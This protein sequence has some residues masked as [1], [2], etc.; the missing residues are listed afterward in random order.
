MR[1]LLLKPNVKL[2]KTSQ[3]GLLFDRSNGMHMLLTG[4]ESF[5]LSMCDGSRTEEDIVIEVERNYGKDKEKCREDVNAFLTSVSNKILITLPQRIQLNKSLPDP[6]Q[7]LSIRPERALIPEKIMTLGISPSYACSLKC[8]YCFAMAGDSL[9]PP[10][11]MDFNLVKRV[12]RE[13]ADLGAE[14]LD[15]GGGDPIDYRYLTTMVKEAFELGY[16]DITVSTKGVNVTSNV[17]KNLRLSGLDRIQMSIDTMDPSLYDSTVGRKGMYERM[18]KGWYNLKKEGF[19]ITNRATITKQTVGTTLDLFERLYS[20]GI[21][22]VRAIGTQL[23]GRATQDMLPP[24]DAM[25]KLRKDAALL[26]ADYANSHWFVG[27]ARFGDPYPCE[28]DISRTWVHPDGRVSLCDVA[29]SY[30]DDYPVFVFGNIKN[31]S[32]EDIWRN[33]IP[34]LFRTIRD[35]RCNSCPIASSCRGDCPLFAA[36][37]QGDVMKAVP[38]CN[39]LESQ[40]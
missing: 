34:A 3:G 28:G 24:L 9:T 38:T 36:T 17:A 26:S 31:E 29:G 5:V 12:L 1:S 21:Y 15:I 25:M 30:L 7:F 40:A 23:F 6:S 27:D 14:R 10:K 33:K 19:H 39:I 2:V 35:P 11:S 16:R 13:A 37:T 32:L 8:I 20:M 22:D 4:T 18:L